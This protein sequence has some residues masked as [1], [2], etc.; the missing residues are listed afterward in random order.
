MQRLKITILL[1]N[2]L[3]AFAASNSAAQTNNTTESDQDIALLQ[4]LIEVDA[5][6][7]ENRLYVR[8]TLLF[9][10]QGTENFSGFLR[11][12]VPDGAQIVVSQNG[13]VVGQ[14]TVQRKYMMN[15]T[16][17]YP[18]QP[19]QE[20]NIVSWRDKIDTTG[21]PPLYVVEYLLLAEPEGTLATKK[22]YSKVFLFP[23]LT[24]Q[25]A[26]IRLIVLKNE[27][28]SVTVTDEKGNSIQASGN[29]KEEDKSVLY[30]WEMPEFKEINLE[31]S[32]TA[33]PQTGTAVYVIIG[34]LIILVL[35][36]PAVRKRSEKIKAVEEKIRSS[37]KRG[38]E[39]TIEVEPS[40]HGKA[41]PEE[42][43]EGKTREEL[44]ALRNEILSKL[45]ELDK[46][47]ESGD[48]LD[49]EYE[50]LRESYREKVK[51][52]DKSIDYISIFK[53]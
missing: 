20:G 42:E 7:Q 39:E 10:N 40:E 47:Y 11:T 52:I 48:L 26:S 27:G 32:K 21:L 23:T 14:D 28:E 34:L 46:K 45:S 13:E 5:V 50:V 31:I 33:V 53:K 30:G 22:H 29:P 8:E 3:I 16:L 43:F 15:G 51:K 12:W 17:E 36:Y 49:E 9:K 2:L 25:P 38:E 35:S 41:T 18:I 1:I 24:K 37:L 19:T 4:H 6:K 44:L